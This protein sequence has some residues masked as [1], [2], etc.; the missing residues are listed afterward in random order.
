MG[1]VA[2]LGESSQTTWFS[3]AGA[4]VLPAENPDEARKAWRSLAEE[5]V[6]VVLTPM[7]AR[8]LEEDIAKADRLLCVTLP[9]GSDPREERAG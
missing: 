3:L 2:V 1:R 4:D 6:V 9:D 5:T 8:A 7:A